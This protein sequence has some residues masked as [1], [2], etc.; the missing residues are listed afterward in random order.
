MADKTLIIV[1]P[2]GVH[3]HLAGEIIKRFEQ[4]GFKLIAAKL[5]TIPKD[6]GRRHYAEHE[7]KHFFESVVDYLCSSPSLVMVWQA[8]GIIPA[9]RKMMGSTFNADPGT[10]RGDF[11]CSQSY[12]I[13]HGSDCTES[14]EREIKLYFNPEEILDYEFA[15]SSWIY[16]KND[17]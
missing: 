12:N 16:G 15:H 1:K 9:A 2:D 17:V 11:G 7:G 14:A 13:I 8:D 4:K 5:M 10:I 6:I 3:R